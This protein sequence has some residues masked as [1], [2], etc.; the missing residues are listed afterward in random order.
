[1]RWMTR[2][3]R[4]ISRQQIS[5]LKGSRKHMGSAME[6]LSNIELIRL[7]KDWD[8][9]MEVIARL[10]H[11]EQTLKEIAALADRMLDGG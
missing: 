2:R 6:N 4:K 3:V 8:V 10:E 9:R 7:I 5:R 1:L 11:Y